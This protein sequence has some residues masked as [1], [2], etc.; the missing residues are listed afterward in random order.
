[1]N[2]DRAQLRVGESL[3]GKY[4]LQRVVGV[5]AMAAVYEATHRNGTRV[6]VKILHR[7][8]AALGEIKKRFQREGYIANRI[9]HPSVVRVIDD[10]EDADGTVFIVMELLEGCTLESELATVG[11]KMAAPRVVAIA[12]ALLDVL[13]VAHAAGVVH[14][15]IKPDNLFLT[16]NGLK[17]LD[18]GIARLMDLSSVTKSGQMMGTAEFISPEQ[19]GGQHN[20]DGRSDL[21]SVGA[22]MFTMLSGKYVQEARTVLEYLVFAATKPARSISAVMPELDVGLAGVIDIALSFDKD[23]RFTT[24]RQMQRAL[25]VAAIGT[26]ETINATGARAL[27][28]ILATRQSAK[29][30]A[31]RPP[32]PRAPEVS[33]TSTLPLVNPNVPIPPKGK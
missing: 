33:R 13:D 25:R 26:Q 17:I 28:A 1:M 23:R 16:N 8:I 5:G 22:M 3:R 6:A 9:D 27:D 30:P 12:D 11:G 15:D 18:F 10:D 32:E 29:A 19:A 24:A 14:R 7:E 2:V 4:L 31:A 20:V 21:F